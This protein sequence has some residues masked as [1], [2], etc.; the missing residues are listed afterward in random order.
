MGIFTRDIETFDQLFLHSLKDMYYAEQQIVETL[1]K[2]I[3]KASNRELKQGLNQHLRETKIQVRRLEEVFALLDEEPATKSCKGIDGILGEGDELMGNIAEQRVLNAAI[4]ASAQ[5]VEHYE[6]TRY[7][8]LIAWAKEMDRSDV[9]RILTQTLKEEK[10]TDKKLSAL[11][12][13]KV[14]RRA[15]GK[16]ATRRASPAKS[17]ASS[18]KKSGKSAKTSQTTRKPAARRKSA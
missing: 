17:R 14:N 18:A 2:L 7:G 6:I 9:A 16:A 5:A 1:P 11:A 8:A 15:D 4:I 3:E 10:A 12:E 13:T